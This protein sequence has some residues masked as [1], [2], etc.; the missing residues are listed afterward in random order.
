MGHEKK[1]LHNKVCVVLSGEDIVMV[2]AVCVVGI[3]MVVAVCVV[4]LVMVV[5]VC[6]VGIMMV[7]VV[8]VVIC[9]QEGVVEEC[10]LFLS[11]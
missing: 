1:R 5:V 10:G 8:C 3:V 2:V 6:V 9:C 7:V 11:G 4:G